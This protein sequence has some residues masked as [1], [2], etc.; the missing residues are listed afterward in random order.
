MSKEADLTVTIPGDL[1]HHMS[2]VFKAIASLEIARIRQECTDE[3]YDTVKSLIMDG[4][5]RVGNDLIQIVGI[6]IANR[7]LGEMGFPQDAAEQYSDIKSKLDDGELS[8]DEMLA[9]MLKNV[10]GNKTIN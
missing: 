9:D 4:M 8:R 5:R 6:E 3:E 7:R 10:A 2:N 1:V